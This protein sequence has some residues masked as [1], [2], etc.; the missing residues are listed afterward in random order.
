[1][2]PTPYTDEQILEALEK[3]FGSLD[4]RGMIMVRPGNKWRSYWDSEKEVRL[5]IGKKFLE[6]LPKSPPEPDPYATLKAYAKAGARIRFEDEFG[7]SEW[8]AN[9]DWSWTQLPEEYQVHPADLHLLEVKPWTPKPGDV[10][11]LKSGGPRMTVRLSQDENYL[12]TWAS[13]Y[14]V[15]ERFFPLACLQQA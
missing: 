1:M 5:Q 10:V 7:W 6:L 13:D 9:E 15:F 2:N 4:S 14:G 3:A 12:C 8:A 11:Q